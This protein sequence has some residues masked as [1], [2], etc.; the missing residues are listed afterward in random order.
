MNLREMMGSKRPTGA[1]VSARVVPVA[2]LG[3]GRR[4]CAHDG[5]AYIR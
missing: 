3:E 5:N 2:R 4:S 1:V